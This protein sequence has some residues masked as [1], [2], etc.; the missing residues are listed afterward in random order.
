MLTLSS[1][2]GDFISCTA[3]SCLRTL[4]VVLAALFLSTQVAADS[5]EETLAHLGAGL[6]HFDQENF[7]EAIR[8][9]ELAVGSDPNLV[10]A[11]YSLGISYFREHRYPEAIRQ[12]EW[13]AATGNKTTAATCYL[14]RIDLLSGNIDSAIQRFESMNASE[15]FEDESFYLGSAYL[16]KGQPEKAVS[17]LR[18]QVEGNPRDF[19][20]HYLLGRAY[21]K[22]GQAEAAK[23]EFEE[24][25]SLHAYYRESKTEITNCRDYLAQGRMEEAWKQCGSVLTGDDIDKLVVVGMMFGEFGYY[26]RAIQL[27]EKALVLDPEAPEINF[28]MGFTHFRRKDYRQARTYLTE[29]VLQRPDFFEALA[30]EGTVLYLLRED[31]AAADALSR[32]S[33]LRPGDAAVTKL[34]DRLS[35]KV[36]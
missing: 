6:K 23:R 15:P 34:L 32:A 20:A 24:T 8:E 18:R 19:R 2:R 13:L 25:R 21:T 3:P 30:L 7:P 33:Q 22:L 26:D 12:F 10:E 9:F 29:A 4:A 5:L 11:R 35:G 27:F 17:A 36:K 16:K 14:G 1:K 28:D 31:V